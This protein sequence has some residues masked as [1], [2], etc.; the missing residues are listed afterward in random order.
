MHVF[1]TGG[2]GFI[3]SYV[4]RELVARGHTVRC[5]VRNP[6]APLAV[7]GQAVEC[8]KGDVTNS[9]TL[10]G[11][12]RG[13][14]AVI[15]LVGIIEEDTG[16]GITFDR[17][18]REGTLH[19]V[20]AAAEAGLDRFVLMSANGARPD[21]VSAYQRSKW[22]A[23]EALTGAGFSHACIIR[24]S[25]VFGDPG[26]GHP[27]FASRLANTLIKPFPILPVFGRGDFLMQPVAV[28]D[29]AAAFVQALTLPAA[30]GCTYTAVGR[31][32][33]TYVAVL[34]RITEAL[35]LRLRPKVPQPLWLVRPLIH[36]LDPLHLLP[37]TADQ[38]DM[39][40]E[41]NTGDPE[42]FFRDFDL[43]GKA[44]TPENLAYLKTRG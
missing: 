42:P 38:F 36:L 21:G 6:D 10:R 19:V 40:V 1:L 17:I 18:H 12:L 13:C 33:L 25:V 29:V 9:R 14:E 43:P 22:A 26:P 16:R 31:E 3:G 30:A 11:T 41:G 20:A 37:I 4:L 5:L 44:F 39:L 28:E 2:T 7:H 32:R 15:H 23:E 27:E 8:V 24:P 35:G 34:D